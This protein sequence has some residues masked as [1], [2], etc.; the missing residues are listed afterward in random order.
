M[1]VKVADT[2]SAKC[3]STR[4]N[5]VS[6]V[7]IERGRCPSGSMGSEPAPRDRCTLIDPH[8]RRARV[9]SIESAHFLLF[10]T[11]TKKVPADY[12]D[13]ARRSVDSAYAWP[14][15][16]CPTELESNE[17]TCGLID[18]LTLTPRLRFTQMVIHA[19]KTRHDARRRLLPAYHRVKR[20]ALDHRWAKKA[21]ARSSFHACPVRH[22]ALQV[23]EAVSDE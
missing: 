5:C 12:N 2:S 18:H 4:V 20:A 1:H 23:L 10:D 14:H 17:Q 3:R 16:R 21:Q 15:A 13:N 7:C 22:D 19:S 11:T 8:Q 6:M 9:R